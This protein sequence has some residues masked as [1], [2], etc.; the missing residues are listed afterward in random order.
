M[1]GT[2][3]L[4]TDQCRTKMFSERPSR[5]AVR[6]PASVDPC[7]DAVS[8]RHVLAPPNSSNVPLIFVRLRTDNPCKGPTGFKDVVEIATSSCDLSRGTCRLMSE[9]S[10]TSATN[11]PP[12]NT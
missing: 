4:I 10:C 9:Y 7:A 1:P 3:R 12:N 2:C 6:K 11:S 8:L 5:L